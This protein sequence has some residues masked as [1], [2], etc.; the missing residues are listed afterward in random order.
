MTIVVDIACPECGRAD[1]V[2]KEGIATYRCEECD[3]EFSHEDVEP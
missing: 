3:H 2:R 1:P